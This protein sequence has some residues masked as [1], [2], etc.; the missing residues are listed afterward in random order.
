MWS[1]TRE[2]TWAT[3]GLSGRRG[4]MSPV[5][6]AGV[7]EAGEAGP[8]VPDRAW[9][10]EP[11]WWPHLD[12]SD[13]RAGRDLAWEVTASEAWKRWHRQRSRPVL[14]QWM[15]P[16]A[17]AW[18]IWAAAAVL[19]MG[20]TQRTVGADVAALAIWGGPLLLLGAALL[21]ATRRG[22]V[23]LADVVADLCWSLEGLL[24]GCVGLAQVLLLWAT[25]THPPWVVQFAWCGLWL[26]AAWPLARWTVA[27]A[28][29]MA[30]PGG[31]WWRPVL[32]DAPLAS[33]L[34]AEGWTWR[35]SR[36]TWAPQPLAWRA[37][38]EGMR[39]VLTGSR[40]AGRPW[41]MLTVHPE[42]GWTI[43]PW[44]VP[45]L[46]ELLP[47]DRWR[48]MGGGVDLAAVQSQ[49]AEPPDLGPFPPLEEK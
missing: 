24:L 10:G 40:V 27:L 16:A 39:L 47:F 37:L 32:L 13:I 45:P 25:G 8:W 26:C 29:A 4:H 48:W 42:S 33:R 30:H 18:G 9:R 41:V 14:T 15:F 36:R 12:A 43:D 46:P 34:E 49:L 6:G 31:A 17:W 3:R 2:D 19:L 35:A 22:G 11:A 21:L 23:V 5:D 1:A 20:L 38:G 28:R 7:S 44:Q